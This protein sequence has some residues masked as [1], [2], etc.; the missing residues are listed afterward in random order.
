M[1]SDCKINK[2]YVHQNWYRFF[3]F[4]IIY[5]TRKTEEERNTESNTLNSKKLK[6]RNRIQNESIGTQDASVLMPLKI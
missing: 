1:H 5:K 4:S 2:N 6:K 3:R